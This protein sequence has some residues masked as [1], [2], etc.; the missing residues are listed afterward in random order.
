MHQVGRSRQVACHHFAPFDPC[1]FYPHFFCDVSQL[2][3]TVFG[4][5]LVLYFESDVPRYR[6]WSQQVGAGGYP[7]ILR[8][9]AITAVWALFGRHEIYLSISSLR[10]GPSRLGNFIISPRALLRGSTSSM[11]LH[12]RYWFCFCFSNSSLRSSATGLFGELRFDHGWDT[13][14]RIAGGVGVFLLIQQ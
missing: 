10:S 9:G 5:C 8:F 2:H 7:L 4:M 12:S 1:F 14:E 11:A 6:R 3:L 13:L